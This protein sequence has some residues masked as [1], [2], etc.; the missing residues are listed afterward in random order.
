MER[1]GDKQRDDPGR[2]RIEC[3]GN[4]LKHEIIAQ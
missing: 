3:G 2:G 4:L 1:N